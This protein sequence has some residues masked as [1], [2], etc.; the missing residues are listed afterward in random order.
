MLEKDKELPQ[1][2]IS[3]LIRAHW[4]AQ[5]L[6]NLFFGF[7]LVVINLFYT[8]FSRESIVRTS[9]LYLAIYFGV[10]VPFYGLL[11]AFLFRRS[12]N[13]FDRLKQGKKVK[14]EEIGRTIEFLLGIPIKIS[15]FIPV[16]VWL[17]FGMGGFV[18]YTGLVPE[19]I[20]LIYLVLVS[21][22]SI[23]FC[24]GLMHSFLNYI[25]LDEYLRPV[26][27]YMGLHFSGSLEQIKMRK[28]PLAVKV[29]LMIL[30]VSFASQ[31]S[32]WAVLSAR[33]GL[34][35]MQELKRASLYS[36]LVSALTLVPVFI[37]GVLFSKN[38]PYP[39]KKLI[40]W[41]GRVIR[42][43][44][45]GDISLI[46]NDEIAYAVEHLKKMVEEL[47][48]S[49]KVLEIRVEARTRELRELTDKQEDIIGE[50]TKE[51]KKKI[52]ELEAFRKV[53]VGRELKMMELKKQL[54]KEG[55]KS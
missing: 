41:S 14:Q 12:K 50:R 22:M 26:I 36:V 24:V 19:F 4:S 25:L 39:L 18:L 23:G 55:N 43:E 10:F 52:K 8:G 6:A 40:D 49:R 17:G 47:E 44:R 33:A 54:K 46:T 31:V 48:D 53:A 34:V 28:L 16:T 3:H 1:F 15:I 11:P 29:F 2:K 5:A 7:S 32:L 51:L 9:L 13:V 42:G 30:L 35:S 20:P 45:A 21:C 37:I 38:I 27:D